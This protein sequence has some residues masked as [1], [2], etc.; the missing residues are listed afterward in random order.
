VDKI[1]GH[2]LRAVRLVLEGKDWTFTILPTLKVLGG[3]H[4]RFMIPSWT[5]ASVASTMLILLKEV[6]SE[7][8]IDSVLQPVVHVLDLVTS[9]ISLDHFIVEQPSMKPM[10]SLMLLPRL[11]VGHQKRSSNAVSRP[12]HRSTRLG[13]M[14]CHLRNCS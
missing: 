11:S 5:H 9:I 1:S 3:I 8:V 10:S 6:L 14:S 4:K 12:N 13:S 2:L 7:E